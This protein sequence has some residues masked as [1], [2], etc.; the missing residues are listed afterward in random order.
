MQKDEGRKM[1]IAIRQN[2]FGTLLGLLAGALPRFEWGSAPTSDIG[3]DEE[4]RERRD[5]V[6]EMMLSSPEAFQHER[7]VLGAM[8]CVRGQF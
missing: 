6:L 4:A 3:D 8:S 5:F 1:T 2:G 7:D